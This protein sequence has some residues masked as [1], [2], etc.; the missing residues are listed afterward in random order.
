M[1]HI[2]LT[3][4]SSLQK[5]ILVQVDKFFHDHE[6]QPLLGGASGTMVTQTNKFRVDTASR[7][8]R[9]LEDLVDAVMPM[10][11]KEGRLTFY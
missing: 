11:E 7:V 6:E 8:Q 9:G 1:S 2:L 5:Q 4:K 3:H 10:L